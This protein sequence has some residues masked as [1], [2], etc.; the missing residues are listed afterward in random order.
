MLPRNIIFRFC[1]N[2]TPFFFPRSKFQR[3][4]PA[5]IHGGLAKHTALILS[6]AQLKMLQSTE[7]YLMNRI[8]AL[9][10]ALFPFVGLILQR[11][12]MGK[13]LHGQR[14]CVSTS[15]HHPLHHAPWTH[16]HTSGALTQHNPQFLQFRGIKN[17]SNQWSIEVIAGCT[18]C[19]CSSALFISVI[20]ATPG[21][22]ARGKNAKELDRS[23]VK[24]WKHSGIRILKDAWTGG[25]PW[26]K[27]KD[28]SKES[29]KDCFCDICDA[30]K[31]ER[32]HHCSAVI[33]T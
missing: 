11:Q 10:C 5:K 3:I 26:E 23:G 32:T 1:T 12:V 6:E 9:C 27:Q 18:L 15:N 28:G 30:V 31:P 29:K 14:S 19:C 16:L 25:R 4:P 7:D 24:D 17:G 13:P 2:C 21:L 22:V 33:A 8:L 20:K